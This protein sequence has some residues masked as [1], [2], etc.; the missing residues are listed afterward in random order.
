MVDGQHVLP[1]RPARITSGCGD[2]DTGPNTGGMGAYSPR[3]GG[4]AGGARPRHARGNPAHRRGH[5]AE[6]MPY[7]GLL[8]AGLMI[9]AGRDPRCIEFN[10]R[11]GDPETQPIMMRL[12]SDSPTCVEAACGTARSTKGE[13]D[14][15]AALGV[16]LA[17]GGYP[18]ESQR[19]RPFNG[20]PDA[21]R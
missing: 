21:A 13:W 10:C 16:V 14:P 8:Y 19:R 6:G 5:G 2:G 3:A 7:T 12:K 20:L 18:G 1:S 11:F 4:H 17:A 15:R 9:D